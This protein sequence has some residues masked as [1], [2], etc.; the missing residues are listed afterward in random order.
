MFLLLLILCMVMFVT[1]GCRKNSDQ[2]SQTD[3]YTT[4]E[5]WTTGTSGSTECDLDVTEQTEP[6]EQTKQTEPT[7]QTE[8]TEQTE[9]TEQTEQTE[10]TEPTEQTEQTEP[11]EQTEQ[12][13]QVPGN[14]ENGWGPIH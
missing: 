6:T 10:Q 7:E 13:E 1:A 3:G 8:Q 5:D 11:T 14:T 2:P 9:P 4:G 12:P